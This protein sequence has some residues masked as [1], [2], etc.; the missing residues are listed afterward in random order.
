MKAMILAAGRG[1]RMRPLTDE[2][3]KPMLRAGGKPLIE[4]HVEALARA[5]IDEIIINLAWRG[6]SIRDY[7]GD[8]SRYGLSLGYSDEGTEAL[9]TGG[10][11]F[12]ALPKLAPGPF[13]LVNGDIFCAFEFSRRSLDPGIEAHLVLVPNPEHHPDGDFRLVNNR[14]RPRNGASLTYTGIALLDPALFRGATGGKFPLAPLLI[15]AA[16]RDAVTGERFDGLWT[17][18]GTPARLG[19]LERTLSRR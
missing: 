7:L 2:L 13:W 9:E 16:R 15:S 3:P 19:D 6:A 4:Y 17:D 1:E 10:G 14:V 11:I 8:G 18:V 5:G 12:R